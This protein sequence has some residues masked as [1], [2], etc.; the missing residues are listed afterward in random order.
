MKVFAMP[1]Q[2]FDMT[3]T[4]E[5]SRDISSDISVFIRSVFRENA[6]YSPTRV[7]P[8]TAFSFSLLAAELH[9]EFP[10]LTRVS[11]NQ[12]NLSTGFWLPKLNELVVQHG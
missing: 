11:F 9:N 5:A 6:A 7:M 8:N 10:E 3:V 2:S 12:A 4:Y 1:T